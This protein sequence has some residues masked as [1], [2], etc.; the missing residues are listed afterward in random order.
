MAVHSLHFSCIFTVPK[1]ESKLL[2][3]VCKILFKLHL[4]HTCLCTPQ[5]SHTSCCYCIVGVLF[6]PWMFP[7]PERPSPEFSKPLCLSLWWLPQVRVKY[8]PYGYP[9]YCQSSP[10]WL[11]LNQFDTHH[12]PGNTQWLQPW[13]HQ[14]SGWET[15]L[16]YI[17]LIFASISWIELYAHLTRV[18]HVCSKLTLCWFYL[19]LQPCF[20]GKYYVIS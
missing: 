4:Q 13:P 8:P 5:T 11:P 18:T 2:N 17:H 7:A 6:P 12:F 9:L 15:P 19:L 3:V 20:L 1:I 14:C 16:E 10:N